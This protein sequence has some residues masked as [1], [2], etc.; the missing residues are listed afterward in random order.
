MTRTHTLPAFVRELLASPPRRGDGLNSWFFRTSRVLHPFLPR[1]E[2][3][4][5]LQVATYGEPLQPGEVKRAVERSAACAWRPG[6]PVQQGLQPPWPT[7]NA[8]QREAVIEAA[9]GLDWWTL[10]RLASVRF[11]DNLPHTEEIID[12]LFPKDPSFVAQ[13]V[14]FGVCDPCA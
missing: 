8:E 12:L 4:E 13:R 1:A 10:G 6:E 5:L 14:Q 7:V 3:I 11:E 2:I 9:D